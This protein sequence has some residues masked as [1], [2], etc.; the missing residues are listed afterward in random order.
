M[1]KPLCTVLIPFDS[2][3]KRRFAVL[4]EIGETLGFDTFRVAQ[5]YSSGLIPEEIVRGIDDAHLLIADLS[6]GNPNVYYEVGIAHALGK[7]V[8]LVA[9]DPQAVTLDFGGLQVH[10]FGDS[11]ESRDV[12]IGQLTRFR[13]TPGAMS[14]ID[15]FS[16]GTAISGQ[17]LIVRRIGSFLID[18]VIASFAGIVLYL[19]LFASFGD[20]EAAGSPLFPILFFALIFVYFFITTLILDATL[21]QRLFRLRVIKYDRSAPSAWQCFF[22]PIAAT[23]GFFLGL[24]FF[25]AAKPPRHQAVH[26]MLTRTLVVKSA[27]LAPSCVETSKSTS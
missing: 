9:D 12:L 1:N 13:D 2:L 24:T 8:F 17:S 27:S 11:P 6:G 20:A 21:G 18:W 25:W 15:V 3:G 4:K 10:Q 5:Y 22:R 19:V 23:M 26:G 7:R 16:G 14:P